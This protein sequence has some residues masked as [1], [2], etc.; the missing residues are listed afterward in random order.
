V[1]PLARV[2]RPRSAALGSA[3]ALTFIVAAVMLFCDRDIAPVFGHLSP[4]AG[5]PHR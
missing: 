2:F 1:I 4:L 5:T 3:F